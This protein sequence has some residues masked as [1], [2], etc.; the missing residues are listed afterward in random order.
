MNMEISPGAPKKWLIT[1]VK[2][3]FPEPP[4]IERARTDCHKIL[5]V[6]GSM[7]KTQRRLLRNLN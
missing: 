2:R 3:T 6:V 1:K 5:K 4:K 7:L